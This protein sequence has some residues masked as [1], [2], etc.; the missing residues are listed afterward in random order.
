MIE[1]QTTHE[2]LALEVLE[3]GHAHNGETP[4]FDVQLLMDL[5]HSKLPHLRAVGFHTMYGEYEDLDNAL[6]ERAE[7]REGGEEERVS[8]EMAEFD[9]GTYYYD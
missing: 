8:D 3:L 7:E 6:L 9:V 2:P 5:L 1:H 4:D